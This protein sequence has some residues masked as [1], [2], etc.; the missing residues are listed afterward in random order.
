MESFDRTR[1]GIITPDD[2]VN[3]DEY[4]RFVNDDVTLLID[5]Y[6]TPERYAPINPGMVATYGNLDLLADCAETL[7]ITRPQSIVFFCN[8]CS[9]VGGKASNL[10]ICST[11][12]DAGQTAGTTISMA[13]VEALQTLGARR[14]A[15]GA[16][17][18]E[19]VTQ[20][21]H[22]FLHEYGFDV[23]SSRSL[24]M[25]SEWEIGNTPPEVWQQL[26]IDID[27]PE[28]D[29]VLLA[30]SG[31]RTAPI[32]ESVEDK[33]R[34]PLISAPAAGLWHALKL[35]KYTRPVNGRGLLL[36]RFLAA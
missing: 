1:I 20:H 9:F 6:R 24:G 17:Y 22:R 18:D 34:K 13:Q 16:P 30:C 27:R 5:R 10:A 11:I 25:K 4:W 3:D 31:I 29:V 15:V 33:L 2:A 8:S 28:A 36:S 26:A 32:I 12:A 7:R 23:V 21:L 35:A 19:D 14:V